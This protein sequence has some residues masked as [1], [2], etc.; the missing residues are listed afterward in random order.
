MTIFEM[1]FILT[2]LNAIWKTC[3]F[4]VVINKNLTV[5]VICIFQSDNILQMDINFETDL[6]MVSYLF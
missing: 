2:C 1:E 3:D 5:A 4:C 6:F